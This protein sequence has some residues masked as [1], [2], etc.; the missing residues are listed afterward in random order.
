M[1]ETL[2][3]QRAALADWLATTQ[4]TLER[5]DWRSAFVGYPRADLRD[6]P[7]PWAP[8]APDVRF[9][10]FTLIGSAG[11]SIF[12]QQP[13]DTVALGGDATWRP[14]SVDTVLDTTTITHQHYPHMA[15]E[16]DR[17]AVFPLERL[18]NLTVAAEIGGLTDRHFSFMGYQ[19]NWV[20]VL[21]AF[22]P[23]LA[24]QVALERPDAVLL[25][26]V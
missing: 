26:P 24:E 17:N 20:M 7:V 14:I 21:D 11:L 25:V 12:G 8:A 5:K 18:R 23:Q 15:A 9:A 10:R 4:M 2:A 16:L 6:L 3:A 22:A 1:A 19:P 13:F